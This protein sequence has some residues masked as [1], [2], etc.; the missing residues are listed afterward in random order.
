MR[1][2]SSTFPGSDP[3]SGV[4]I[5]RRWES[6]TAMANVERFQFYSAKDGVLW[7]LIGA[8]HR[9]LGM[10]PDWF[11]DRDTA[12]SAVR[13]LRKIVM[14]ART[15]V[16]MTRAAQWRWSMYAPD[17]TKIAQSARPYPRRIDCGAAA[18]RFR[19]A[20]LKAVIDQRLMAL[21]V[22]EEN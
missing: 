3:E 15:D 21:R 7:R 5:R 22:Y 6:T 20:V 8:N 4:D 10:T 18:D 16:V 13:A 9:V 2:R 14:L 1:G 11:P 17:D 19:D 12:E